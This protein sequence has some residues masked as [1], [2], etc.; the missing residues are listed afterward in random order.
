MKKV[1]ICD[2]RLVSPF[3]VTICDLKFDRSSLVN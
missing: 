2:L 3:K 1:T